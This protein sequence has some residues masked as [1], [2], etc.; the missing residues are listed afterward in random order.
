MGRGGDEKVGSNR[1]LF[2][3]KLI[4]QL[5]SGTESEEEKILVAFQFNRGTESRKKNQY[6]LRKKNY[7]SSSD[8]ILG[9]N[10]LLDRIKK[11]NRNKNNNQYSGGEEK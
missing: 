5:N 1:Y 9:L 7:V 11:Q 4:L 10:R 2:L 8:S 3:A 6:L